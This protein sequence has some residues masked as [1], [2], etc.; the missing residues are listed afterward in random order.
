ME[1]ATLIVTIISAIVGTGGIASIIIALFSIRKYKAEALQI[2]Q[3]T[4]MARRESEQ[5]MNEYIRAQL[6]ELSDTHKKESD[7][8]RKQNKEL[9]DEIVNLNNKVNQ[10]MS[11]IV[12]E[13][14]TYRSWLE[15][16]LRK[17]K[18]DIKFPKC[19]PAPGFTDFHLNPEDNSDYCN[20]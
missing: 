1:T 2:E 13:N 14:L 16:E 4:E 19:Q 9:S 8:L 10:L 11:W 20:A 18:P 12:G 17:L 3:Q 5:K 7:E 6:K 15:N